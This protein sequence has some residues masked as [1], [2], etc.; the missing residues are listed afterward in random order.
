MAVGMCNATELHVCNVDDVR[1]NI[2]QR[3]GN[4][5][6]ADRLVPTL[7]EDIETLPR[8]RMLWGSLQQRMGTQST[9]A[10]VIAIKHA[11]LRSQISQP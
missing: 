7:P 2:R 3:T 4:Q 10:Q 6:W 9:P 11:L 1:Q 8:A 5:W